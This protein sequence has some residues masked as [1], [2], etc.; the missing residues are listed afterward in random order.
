MRRAV[1][2]LVVVA[3]C[4]GKLADDPV[5]TTENERP[6]DRR[7]SSG[8]SSSG[9]TPPPIDDAVTPLENR[10]GADSVPCTSSACVSLSCI[11]VT[12]V[13]LAG[14][15]LMARGLEDVV[16]AASAVASTLDGSISTLR[17]ANGDPSTYEIRNG[18]GFVR[19]PQPGGGPIG[20]WTFRRLDVRVGGIVFQGDAAAVLAARSD[21]TLAP[22][23]VLDVSAR[24]QTPG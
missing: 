18:I 24:G 21:V 11:G 8:G 20:V 7:S 14:D 1:I 5:G 6:A 15:R 19:A 17:P 4:G 9:S 2:G 16:V 23:T 12:H 3:A 22:G 13:P 10:C